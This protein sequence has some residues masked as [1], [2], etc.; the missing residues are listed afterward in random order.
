MHR[1]FLPPDALQGRERATLSGELAH[2]VARVLRLRPGDHVTL[3][4]DTGLAYEAELELV[5]PR[6]ATARLLRAFAPDTE[7]R[8]R[9]ILYQALPRADRMDFVL[10]KNTELGVAAFAPLVAERC[11]ARDAQPGPQ[12]LARWRRII[13]EAAEQAGR[14]RLPALLP[15]Q[16]LSAALAALSAA[17]LPAQALALLGA[18]EGPAPSLRA[19]L[20]PLPAP[21]PSTV[22]V[23]IGPE[24]G[25]SPQEVAQAQAA[26][27]RPFTLGPRI[28]R[29]ETAGLVAC[30]AILYALEEP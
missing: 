17:S 3:L 2:Q 24:G 26:G 10:Q 1:F 27:A 19:L 20:E 28:L 11:A 29:T 22:C 15:V 4:D 23:F 7:P 18:H 8:T 6:Q 5:T 12:R 30:A 13:Q 21:K 16:P 25:F 9:L 14:A